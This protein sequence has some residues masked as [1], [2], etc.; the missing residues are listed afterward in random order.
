MA[1]EDQILDE[2]VWSNPSFSKNP[3]WGG[4]HTNSVLWYFAES[5]YFEQMS[6]NTV[7]LRQLEHNPQLNWILFNRDAFEARMRTMNGVEFIVGEQPADQGPGGTGVWVI[8]KQM[9]RKRQGEADE[10][11]LLNTY[12]VVGEHVYMAPVVADL[13]GSRMVS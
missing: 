13:L 7:L 8:R 4:I 12:H 11:T 9:R 3:V 6:N 1:A 5:P 2:I 10:V